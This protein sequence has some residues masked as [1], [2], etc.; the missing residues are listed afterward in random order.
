MTYHDVPVAARDAVAALALV[1]DHALVDLALDDG[2]FGLEGLLLGAGL[3]GAVGAARVALDDGRA[4]LL[5]EVRVGAAALA[6]DDV[7]LDVLHEAVVDL[8]LGELPLEDEAAVL[9]AA[10]RAD[11]A[12]QDGHEVVVRAVELVQDLA[13]V[14][15]DGR[16]P[17]LE[18]LRLGH[19]EALARA[20]RLGHLA[21]GALEE[22]GVII[23]HG[24]ALGRSPG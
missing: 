3:D 7:R 18:D 10:R 5:H 16:L 1:L 23:G 2:L 13:H 4:L 12:Q 21:A 9:V 14:A 22:G 15:D 8:L 24:A 17:F 19:D 11:L 6:A 20:D